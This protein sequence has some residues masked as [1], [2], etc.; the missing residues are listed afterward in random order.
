MHDYAQEQLSREPPQEF[1]S[2]NNQN[3]PIY[4]DYEPV[5]NRNKPQTVTFE[6][7]VRQQK[8]NFNPS[9]QPSMDHEP[10]VGRESRDLTGNERF[11]DKKKKYDYAEDLRNQMRQKEM[12]KQQEKNEIRSSLQRSNSNISRGFHVKFGSR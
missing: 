6:E 7:P 10:L 12:Q 9:F 1:P 3:Q 4:S 11:D 8:V 2:R 5:V